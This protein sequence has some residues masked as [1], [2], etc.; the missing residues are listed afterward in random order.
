MISHCA[1]EVS[2]KAGGSK[3]AVYAWL[4]CPKSHMVACSARA[5]TI[6]ERLVTL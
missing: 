5:R 3:F 4:I 1:L 6:T 2:L